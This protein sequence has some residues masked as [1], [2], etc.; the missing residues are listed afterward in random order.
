MQCNDYFNVWAILK[1]T[2]LPAIIKAILQL[3]HLLSLRRKTTKQEIQDVK[4]TES[5]DILIIINTYVINNHCM[6]SFYKLEFKNIA[7]FAFH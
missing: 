2:L 4:T 5:C 1:R 6:Q 7:R 3:M